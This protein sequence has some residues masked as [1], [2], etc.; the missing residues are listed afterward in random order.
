MYIY[1]EGTEKDVDSAIQWFKEAANQNDNTAIY[2]LGEIYYH[3]QGVEQDYRKAFG[4]FKI[5]VER[6]FSQAQLRLGYCYLLGHGCGKD[7]ERGLTLIEANSGGN[8]SILIALAEAYHTA[9]PKHR[10]FLKSLKYY[11]K[12]SEGI[13]RSYA[14]RGIGLLYEHGDGVEQ[15]YQKALTYY[16]NAAKENNKAAYYNIAL[17]YHHGYGVNKDYTTSLEWFA[18]VV[19]ENSIPGT[20]H[21]CVFNEGVDGSKIYSLEPESF[22]YGEAHFYLGTMFKNGQGTIVDE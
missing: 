21:V 4:Y 12:I 22:F 14:L 6:G 9:S 10:N 16:Q 1:G 13:Q 19:V 7:E 5:A 2:N 17:L 8:D 18:K 3:G 15:N 11:Q 20:T